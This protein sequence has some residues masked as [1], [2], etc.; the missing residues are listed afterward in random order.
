MCDRVRNRNSNLFLL[1]WDLFIQRLLT[2]DKMFHP[3]AHK[4]CIEKKINFCKINMVEIKKKYHFNSYLLNEY[5]GDGKEVTKWNVAIWRISK[6]KMLCTFCPWTWRRGTKRKQINKVEQIKSSFSMRKRSE[7]I[8]N[9]MKSI[10]LLTSAFV[11]NRIVAKFFVSIFHWFN[12]RQNVNLY[13]IMFLINYS[14][15][16]LQL[17]VVWR[18]Q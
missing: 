15:I 3:S 9:Y 2:D 4:L 11:A 5:F 1:R 7:K 8:K 17:L 13:F 12:N 18:M 16:T 14:I 6:T 10:Y